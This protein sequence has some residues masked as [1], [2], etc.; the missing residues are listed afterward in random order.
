MT[1]PQF[2][3][4]YFTELIRALAQAA[5]QDILSQVGDEQVYAF[6]LYTNGEGSYVLSMANTEEALER[7][8][9]TYAQGNTTLCAL[10][11]QSLRW[12]PCDWQYHEEGGEAASE[13]VAQYLETGWN[14]DYTH[15]RFNVELVE[16]C[17]IVALRQLQ[18]EYFFMF[19]EPK[20]QC[21]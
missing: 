21:W 7:K 18:H 19:Q 2:D 10:H 9:L 17:C 15:Y 11:R 5:F 6:G 3:A 14:A 1:L 13:S 20:N 12:S 16:R 8:A 4:T